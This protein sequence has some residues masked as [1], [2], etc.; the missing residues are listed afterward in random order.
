QSTTS[1]VP[2]EQS[3]DSVAVPPVL[4]NLHKCQACGFPVSQGRTFCVE[5]E[6]KQWRGQVP[7]AASK[8]PASGEA[9]VPPSAV[10]TVP[11]SAA[12][13]VA[14]TVLSSPQSVDSLPALK[15]SASAPVS[16]NSTLFLSAAAPSESW[17]AANKYILGALL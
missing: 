17:F 8:A 16:E 11:R 10:A 7:V 2:I 14:P 9:A 5:C 3:L 4:R 1:A 12:T 6:E 13:V 15:N